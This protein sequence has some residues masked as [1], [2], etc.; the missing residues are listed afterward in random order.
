MCVCVQVY[1]SFYLHPNVLNQIQMLSITLTDAKLQHRSTSIQYWHVKFF[2]VDLR[3]LG[4]QLGSSSERLL[5]LPIYGAIIFHTLYEN[6]VVKL[7][8]EAYKPNGPIGVAIMSHSMKCR[9]TTIVKIK[10]QKRICKLYGYSILRNLLQYF[11]NK[12]IYIP[13]YTYTY[14]IYDSDQASLVTITHSYWVVLI[15]IHLCYH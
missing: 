3:N 4:S 12:M 7:R 8:H 15:L 9:S 1:I 14:T 10:H 11:V 2:I 5:A 6:L 13:I